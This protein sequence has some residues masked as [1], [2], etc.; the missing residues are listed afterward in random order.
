MDEE[1]KYEPE[2][3]HEWSRRADNNSPSTADPAVH[4]AFT[5]AIQSYGQNGSYDDSHNPQDHDRHENCEAS[6]IVKKL[7]LSE[8]LK[9]LVEWPSS[10]E[11]RAGV[12][13]SPYRKL[14]R[15]EVQKLGMG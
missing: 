12:D 11:S 10:R 7:S 1:G 6:H 14:R 13:N 9:E 2:E 4:P 5:N 15:R 8:R 3:A